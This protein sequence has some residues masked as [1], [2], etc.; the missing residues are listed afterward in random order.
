MRR[1]L[2]EYY[3][4]ERKRLKSRYLDELYTF[5][6]FLGLKRPTEPPKRTA[7]EEI[8]NA[9]SHGIGALLSL[10]ALVFVLTR[11]KAPTSLLGAA[12]Y[13]FGLFAMFASSCLYHAFLYGT[14]AKRILRRFDYAG[15]YLFIGA[16]FFPLF[17]ALFSSGTAVLL[18]A[19][20]G[21]IIATAISLVAL[22]GVKESPT[23]HVLFCLFLGWSGGFLLP[24]ILS[25]NVGAALSILGGGVLYTVG[26]IPW[27]IKKCGSH[28]IWH[29]FVLF[30][31]L[32]QS[33]GVLQ[34]L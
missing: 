23:P 17:L 26:I 21:V 24:R 1:D 5:Y 25:I 20:Q 6:D 15:I 32:V 16:T 10:V 29:I 9:V 12:V 31:S 19:M 30:G 4:K 34:F 18:I 27:F 13:F 11:T 22:F 8:A 7:K 14:T 33:L 2:N 28:F 3:K